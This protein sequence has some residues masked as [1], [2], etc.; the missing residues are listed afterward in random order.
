MAED[1]CYSVSLRL[2]SSTNLFDAE[3]IV[4]LKEW[5]YKALSKV[6]EPAIKIMIYLVSEA[7][8]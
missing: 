7:S 6:A 4:K 3:V 5:D 8:Q 1:I 2:S